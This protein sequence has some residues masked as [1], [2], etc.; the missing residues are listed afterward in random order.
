[1][2]RITIVGLGLLGTSL[3]MALKRADKRG[4]RIT[5]FDADMKVAR[6]SK[7]RGAIDHVE[8]D[9]AKAVAVAEVVVIATPAR[10]VKTVLEA[11]AG[12]VTQGA[13]VTDVA[14]TK[15]QVMAWAE[16]LLPR[17]VSFIGGH[18]MAG[19]EL[20]GPEAAK[21]DLFVGARWCLMPGRH[22]TE[23]ALQSV[24]AMAESVGAKTLFI[25]PQ[26]HDLLV[27]G[28]SHAPIALSAALVAS[29]SRSASW[30]E[31]AGLAAGGYRDV[32]RLA[33]G[34][35]TMSVDICLTNADAIEEWLGRCIAALEE[36]RTHV[37]A[38]DAEQ[39]IRLFSEVYSE[40]ERWLAGVAQ[41][42][43]S[44]SKVEIPTMGDSA[45]RT[46]F[47]EA[48][49]KQTKRLFEL[50]NNP[51]LRSRPETEDDKHGSGAAKPPPK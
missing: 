21:A 13:V 16:E 19:L 7:G 39:L 11:I 5:G 10:A 26:E 25:D 8:D 45:Y 28:I 17:G 4:H 27:A 40:R 47:G 33:S 41:E 2:A 3:G 43:H 31:M 1:M 9:L 38:Q 22:A 36:I 14:S 20:S 37:K 35:P 18:P 15:R 32:S 34:S 24:M 30:P 46:L 50:S 29:T 42:R 44:K 49:Y 51:T 23:G 6:K 12:H 48:M